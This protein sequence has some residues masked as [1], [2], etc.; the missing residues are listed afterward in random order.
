[1][2]TQNLQRPDHIISLASSGILINV[3]I[4]AWGATK[5]D[6]A[7]SEEVTATKKADRNSGSFTKK[8]LSNSTDHRA[9]MNERQ[10]IYNWI[11]RTT[12]PW[13][14]SWR[15]LPT[16]QVQDFMKQ[17]KEREQNFRNLVEKLIAVLPTAISDQAFTQGEMFNRDDYPSDDEVRRKFGIKLYTAEVPV[18][19]W[20]NKIADDL[21]D[22]LTQHFNAQASEMIQKIYEHQVQNLVDVMESIA[23]ACTTEVVTENNETKVIRRRLY[24]TTFTRL[25]ELAQQYRG[26][27]LAG[28]TKLSEAAETLSRVLNNVSIEQLRHSEGLKTEVKA[29]MEDLLAKFR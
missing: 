12:Y 17:F 7:I 18:G 25:Q 5:Q 20:R 24:D 10:N 8:L 29:T 15:Y 21:A 23:H 14:G 3:E 27:N 19:D 22:D 4:S 9:C 28:S 6:N 1:M 13:A 11:A 16:A 26:F 2:E